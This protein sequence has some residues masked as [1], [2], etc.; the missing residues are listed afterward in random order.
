MSHLDK[1]IIEKIN[2][3]WLLRGEY[4][5]VEEIIDCP[6]CGEEMCAIK[7]KKESKIYLH[8]T[9]RPLDVYDVKENS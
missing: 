6:F 2:V 9:C 8:A 5:T 3:Q 4:E 7:V 1:K